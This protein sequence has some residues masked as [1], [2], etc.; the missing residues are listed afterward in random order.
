MFYLY[1]RLEYV[2]HA[3]LTSRCNFTAPLFVLFS[4]FSND[5]IGWNERKQKKLKADIRVERVADSKIVKRVW[6]LHFFLK[7]TFQ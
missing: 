3:I 2:R 7:N 6:N 4:C 1:N 5:S